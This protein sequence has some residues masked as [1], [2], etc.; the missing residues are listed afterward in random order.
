VRWIPRGLPG[1]GHLTAFNNGPG[2]GYSSI[3]EIELPRDADGGYIL[4]DEGRF[5]PTDLAWEYTAEN[6]KDFYSSFISGATRLPNGNTMICEGATGRFFEVNREGTKLWEHKNTF[7]GEL[8]QDGRP[9]DVGQEARRLLDAKGQRSIVDNNA[10]F[11]ATKFSPGYKGL[12]GR[13]LAPLVE[14]PVAFAT[15][16]KD[17]LARLKAAESEKLAAEPAAAT[18][19][20]DGSGRKS[21][22]TDAPKGAD[23]PGN[24]AGATGKPAGQTEASA[25]SAAPR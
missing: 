19:G 2:R 10:L 14:Q 15:L 11:R 8:S 5:G 22:E 16:V 6:K 1:S 21:S 12:A 23:G 13:K 18:P 3:V 7:G 24:P 4:D 20:E 17:E 25:E 9:I